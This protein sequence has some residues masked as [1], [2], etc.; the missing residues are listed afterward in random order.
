MR[1]ASGSFLNAEHPPVTLSCIPGQPEA[2]A[3]LCQYQE[4]TDTASEMVMFYSE[5]QQNGKNYRFPYRAL[6]PPRER[7]AHLPSE[8]TGKRSRHNRTLHVSTWHFLLTPPL[9]AKI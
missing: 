4:D 5:A 6:K 7:A 9:S 3:T 8:Q 2:H 1:A